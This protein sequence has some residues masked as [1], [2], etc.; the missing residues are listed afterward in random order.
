MNKLYTGHRSKY[1]E[2][3][4]SFRYQDAL[5]ELAQG[6]NLMNQYFADN[7][8]WVLRKSDLEKMA[9]VLHYTVEG[10]RCIAILLQPFC[11]SASTK[12]LDQLGVPQDERGFDN[13]S[14]KFALKPGSPLPEPQ[15]VF[16]RLQLEEKA[17]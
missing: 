9:E 3:M 10:I 2:A 7:E 4:K 8:P 14:D 17:A 6:A 16:P 13:L 12:L 11:P 5:M 15:G 1:L